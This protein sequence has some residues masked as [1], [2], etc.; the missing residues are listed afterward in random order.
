MIQAIA[1]LEDQVRFM[2]EPC[3]AMRK[4]LLFVLFLWYTVPERNEGAEQAARFD[5][6]W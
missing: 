6:N 5:D 2:R 1:G 3:A 4:K